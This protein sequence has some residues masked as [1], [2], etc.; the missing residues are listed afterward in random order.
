MKFTA[1]LESTGGN[2]AGFRVPERVVAGLAGGKR[3]K[4]TVTL[5]GYTY[6]S[7]IAAMGGEYWL[8]VAMAHREP[9]AVE[10]GGTYEVEVELDVAPRVVELPAELAEAFEAE[11][12]LAQAWAALSYSNQ[13]CLAEP[14]GQAKAE[15]TRARRVAKVVAELRG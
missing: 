5:N 1:E 8:G 11:P 3:P 6:R 12:A 14:I 10:P 9:A 4:V 13:R 2:T 15:D 7:S